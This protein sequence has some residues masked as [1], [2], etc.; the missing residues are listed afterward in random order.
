MAA[1]GKAKMDV[2]SHK[3]LSLLNLVVFT[4]MLCYGSGFVFPI[5]VEKKSKNRILRTPE[6]VYCQFK[7]KEQGMPRCLNSQ[8]KCQESK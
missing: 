2:Q 3:T 1:R 4:K 5:F 8:V 7:M 6:H